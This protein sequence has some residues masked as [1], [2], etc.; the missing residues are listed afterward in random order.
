MFHLYLLSK[1][2]Y[3]LMLCVRANS[4]LVIQTG[5]AC[6]SDPQQGCYMV[7]LVGHS[8]PLSCTHGNQLGTLQLPTTFHTISGYRVSMFPYQ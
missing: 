1:E 2:A 4:S 6:V 8:S 5:K 7:I 3:E